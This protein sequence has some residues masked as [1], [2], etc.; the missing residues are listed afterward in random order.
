[1][2]GFR[3]QVS[4]DKDDKQLARV[5]SA[6]AK[7]TRQQGLS[8]QPRCARTVCL[9]LCLSRLESRSHSNNIYCNLS[10]FLALTLSRIFSHL[11][12]HIPRLNIHKFLI[13]NPSNKKTP[14]RKAS[15]FFVRKTWLI[16][17][18]VADQPLWMGSRKS[19]VRFSHH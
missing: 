14:T 12:S 13:F 6:S 2:S 3:F 16:F 17:A 15:G 11:I 4:E 8:D 1:M 7:F 18:T 5:V 9:I 19:G 10:R